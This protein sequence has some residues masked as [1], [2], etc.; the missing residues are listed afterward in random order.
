MLNK[1]N[2]LIIFFQVGTY[3][4]P[5][6]SGFNKFY[7][8]S[9]LEH[10]A[11]SKMHHLSYLIMDNNFITQK[12]C[13]HTIDENILEK[14]ANELLFCDTMI[15]YGLNFH[16]NVL[17]SECH[18]QNEQ[19]QLRNTLQ[20][21]KQICLMK[22]SKYKTCGLIPLYNKMFNAHIVKL[23][24]ND[25]ILCKKIYMK[26]IDKTYTNK[27]NTIIIDLETTG[28]PQNRG[29]M[30][31]YNPSDFQ[32]YDSSRIIEISYSILD[33]NHIKIKHFSSLIT[34]PEDTQM[35]NPVSHITIE[36]LNR[37]G[38]NIG[39]VFKELLEDVKT[40]GTMVAHN[41]LFDL[42]VL[43]S[44]CYRHNDHELIHHIND[45]NMM[46]TMALSISKK[47]KNKK[48]ISVYEELFKEKAI[49]SHRASNDVEICSKIYLELIK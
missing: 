2:N 28:L 14:F 20:N 46:C 18:R 43:L 44:E 33:E 12:L 15:A 21:K 1:S 41:I 30:N 11:K 32:H 6:K 3:G 19:Y 49:E 5:D 16:L 26:I 36:M 13:T 7:E 37:S 47:M 25:L 31:Y 29:Y 9:Q 24:L 22:A 23:K 39:V 35:T 38:N 42:N 40:C 27:K 8:P 34:I 4:L 10:Y 48:L 45:M 17:L